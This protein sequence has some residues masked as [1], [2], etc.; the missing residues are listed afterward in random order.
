MTSADHKWYQS[1]YQTCP[2]GSVQELTVIVVVGR[3][4]AGLG[5]GALSLLVGLS[6]SKCLNLILCDDTNFV[7]IRYPCIK[8]RAHLVKFGVL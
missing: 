2:S 8:V 3:W 1:K 6:S 7:I 4:I 5:V